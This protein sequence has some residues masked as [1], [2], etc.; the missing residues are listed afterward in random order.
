MD[1]SVLHITMTSVFLSSSMAHFIYGVISMLAFD[2]SVLCF[3]GDFLPSIITG[4]E[5][6]VKVMTVS[7]GIVAKTGLIFSKY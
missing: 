7:L 2:C 6:W 5:T 1:L 4:V 3:Q